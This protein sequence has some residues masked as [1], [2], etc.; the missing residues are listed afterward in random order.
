M[1]MIMMKIL[2]R[3][4]FLIETDLHSKY[5]QEFCS[6]TTW[7]KKCTHIFLSCFTVKLFNVRFRG[8]KCDAQ[9][10]GNV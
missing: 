5:K 7:I 1:I 2:K 9:H 4:I 8:V 3:F 6:K 10:T